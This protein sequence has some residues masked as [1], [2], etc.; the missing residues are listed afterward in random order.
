MFQKKLS[1][2][3]KSVL[4]VFQGTFKGVSS[5]FQGGFERG[6]KLFFKVFLLLTVWFNGVSKKLKGVLRIFIEYFWVISK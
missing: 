4:K 6:F 3:F 5:D 1:G 2:W